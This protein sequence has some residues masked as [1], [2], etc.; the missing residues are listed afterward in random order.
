M[1]GD[2]TNIQ[3]GPK[4]KAPTAFRRWG[5]ELGQER[6]GLAASV[7]PSSTKRLYRFDSCKQNYR[8]IQTNASHQRWLATVTRGG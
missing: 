3:L 8:D 4:T 5:P 6:P 7:S 1:P 2:T